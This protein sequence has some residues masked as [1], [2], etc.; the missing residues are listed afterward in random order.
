MR[1]ERISQ[2]TDERGNCR[3]LAKGVTV[4][5][6]TWTTGL[7]NNDLIIGP[8]GAGKTRGYVKPN[9]M[10]ANESLVITDTKGNLY[11]EM[12][13]LLK[14]HG[15][16]TLLI[17][18]KNMKSNCGYNPLDYISYD[19]ER[20][21]YSEE[22]IMKLCTAI[23]PE[24][25]NQKDPYW[26]NAA[27]QYLECLM[28]YVMQY[29]PPEEHTLEYVIRLSEMMK[30]NVFADLMR[31]VKMLAPDGYAA[32]I[33][34]QIEG[35]A[36]AE[37]MN[38]S[39]LGILSENLNGLSTRSLL[40]VYSHPDRLVFEKI[41]QEKTA[42]FLSVSDTDRSQD[43]L[44][45]LFYMQAFQAL[46]DY[47]D[48]E[49]ENSALPVPVRFILDDFAANCVIRD[50]DNL[51]SVIR[52]REIY[53]SIILQSI[54]QLEA[55]YGPGK[56]QTIINN[57]DHCLYL[58]GQDIKTAEYMSIK[59]NKTMNTVLNMPLDKAWLF[60]RGSGAS[61]VEKYDIREHRRYG[62]LP[63]AQ[64]QRRAPGNTGN[65]GNIGKTGKTKSMIS[66][67]RLDG[68]CA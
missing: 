15:Y 33:Y 60:A 8:S 20:Q 24:S 40:Q 66:P 23:T 7:N 6:D 1:D 68:F 26:Q 65:T 56:S 62:E 17:D 39:V 42:V 32:R 31:E 47:A 51:I 11:R 55:I 61:L 19:D 16:R 46:C 64:K 52:S 48:N 28:A 9:I 13:P 53:V 36:T 57:C 37:K 12:S 50:F 30:T 67:Q 10:Q 2:M 35:N 21:C 18:F 27:R 14:K 22:S 5:N 3:I 59:V 29:L 45:S 63:E 41:G 4:S 49:C 54:S 34:R 25:S 44:I 43:R 58:G 38:A